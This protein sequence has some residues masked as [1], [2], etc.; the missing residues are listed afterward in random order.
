MSKFDGIFRDLATQLI[1]NTFGTSAT[2][3][4]QTS[5]YDPVTGDNTRSNTDISVSISPPA[6]AREGRRPDNAL[7]QQGDAECYMAAKG[8]SVVP[9]PVD[10][11]LIW[12]GDTYQVV[13]VFNIVS[14]DQNA[15]YRLILRR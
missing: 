14:G 9:S 1:D 4:R 12:N 5:V 6:P 13:A 8:L 11:K 3:R 2:L 7:V 10:D 15:A